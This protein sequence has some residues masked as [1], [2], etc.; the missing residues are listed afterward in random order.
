MIR[1]LSKV[2]KHQQI[3]IEELENSNNNQKPILIDVDTI[4]DSYRDNDTIRKEEHNNIIEHYN[5]ELEKVANIVSQKN[6]EYEQIQIENNKLQRILTRSQNV[7]R[8]QQELIDKM[9]S[10][11]KNRGKVDEISSG[12][13]YK[14]EF[15]DIE[16]GVEEEDNSD[17]G[18]IEH[19]DGESF[20]EVNTSYISQDDDKKIVNRNDNSTFI[21]P[22]LPVSPS[23][24]AIVNN[25]NSPIYDNIN[26]ENIENEDNN[27]TDDYH[28]PS[29]L[30][31]NIKDIKKQYDISSPQEDTNYH[32]E[33]QND[34]ICSRDLSD[35][36]QYETET[37][38]YE[39]ESY[40]RSENDITN[41]HD[42]KSFVDNDSTLH[43]SFDSVLSNGSKSINSNNDNN[44]Y[45]ATEPNPNE[46]NGNENDVS[47]L[48]CIDQENLASNQLKH[49]ND[50]QSN[51][52][53]IDFDLRVSSNSTI[54]N[55][56]RWKNVSN[57]EDSF[58]LIQNYYMRDSLVVSETSNEDYG[59]NDGDSI[60]S[61]AM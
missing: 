44:S 47:F 8:A 16:E 18:S 59:D 5:R 6:N 10:S 22:P 7:I 9:E 61:G 25:F 3:T 56:S 11:R 20:E 45:S 14:Q 36:V 2:V 32:E 35:E 27:S 50:I 40:S 53:S 43:Q 19:D 48:S 57:V 28:D 34:Q 41:I 4:T 42:F 1:K 31:S 12:R 51:H 39:D 24:T 17:D 13:I 58:A 21:R 49:S 33:N 55:M 54:S 60:P 15:D 52:S 29:L 37:N 38:N 26:F 23:K 30:L 46:N